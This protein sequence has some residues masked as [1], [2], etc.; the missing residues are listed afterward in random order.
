MLDETTF[1]GRRL[2]I[3]GSICRDVKTAPIQA[4]ENLLRDGETPTDFIVETVGGGG[5]NSALFAAG[6]GA[7]TRFAGKLGDDA[8]GARLRQALLDRG[9]A[10]F[11]RHDPAV[12][13]G[14][15]LALTYSNGC[16]HFIS[17]QP[18]NYTLDFSDIDL[19]M[20]DG[21]EHLLRA[22]VWFS[23][24]M[25]ESGNARLLQAAR[26]R[27][28]ATSLDLNWDPCWGSGDDALIRSRKGSVRRI[29]PLADVV[30]GNVN[31]LNRFADST[32]LPTT[33]RRLVDWGARAVVVHHGAQ[34]AGY[35]CDAQLVVEPSAP[36]RKHVNATGCGDLL[37]VC[38]MLLHRHVEI[39]IAERLRLANRI[40]ADFIEGNRAFLPGLVAV[41]G[42]K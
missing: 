19:A 20:L 25:L 38:I 42:R 18:N 36:V 3:V 29:L 4:G 11:I 37:S 21:G 8:L 2:C 28:L 16:R 7:E 34:G 33:L 26:D 39:P 30:H 22:D 9:I 31:E 35:Y 32:D 40:V 41:S 13:T 23:Q 24:P 1:R 10:T 14:S 17:H 6:L 27:G 12:P 15:S 5:A